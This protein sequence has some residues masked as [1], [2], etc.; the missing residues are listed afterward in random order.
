M[1]LNCTLVFSNL[2][3]NPFCKKTEFTL[4]PYLIERG[5]EPLLTE[6]IFI[7]IPPNKIFLI[8]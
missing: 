7:S 6:L 8:R 1:Q 3:A 2:P 4:E 5:T